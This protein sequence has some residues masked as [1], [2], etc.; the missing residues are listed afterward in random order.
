LIQTKS[1]RSGLR[2]AHER[3]RPKRYDDFVGYTAGVRILDANGRPIHK[4]QVKL[5]SRHREAMRSKYSEYWRMAQDD[6]FNSLLIKGVLQEISDVE[7]PDVAQAIRTMW[8][9]ALKTDHLGFVVRFKARLVAL[10][11]WQRPGIDFVETFAPVARMSSFRM[12]LGLAAELNLQ[13][14]GGDINTAYLNAK[15]TI[16]QYVKGIE[17]FP[18]STRGHIYIVKKAL[19]GLRQAGREW[20]DELNGWLLSHGFNRNSTEPC[21]YY[22]IDEDVI[23]IVLVYVDDILCAT[24]NE[25]SKIKLFSMLGEDY[26]I[27]D[28]G[29]LCEYLG[30]EITQSATEIKICQSKY[31]KEIVEKFGYE[32]AHSV[33]NPMETTSRLIPGDATD[34]TD[35]DFDYR[36]AIGMLM[37]LAT[38]T[39]P[40]LAYS[41]SQLSRFVANPTLKHIGTV[42]RVLRYLVGTLDKGI[43]Y[44]RNCVV[45]N[46]KTINLHGYCD[47]DWANDSETRKSTTGFIFTLAGGAISWMSRRQSIVA[48]STAE[49]EYVAV[50]EA[51]MEAMGL[52]NIMKEMFRS[53]SLDVNIGLDS[54]S[55]YVMAT[56]PTYSRRT[57]HIELRWHFVREQVKHGFVK[58]QKIKGED[59]PADVFT[60]P[61]DKLRLNRLMNVT[62]VT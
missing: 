43:M 52:R 33:G 26:G 32:N 62:G 17:G 40:D 25:D 7:M 48:L 2:E 31:A 36:A 46:A 13:V 59:N 54:Q 6:E 53:K 38:S 37:Y 8:I 24:N 10:G 60:K 15:L 41:M 5:P 56:N 27:K 39:R 4:S 14:Y 11:N 30:V 58:L 47:S 28:Q 42:K 1:R 45:D 55:A 12:V 19:Y 57:R 34:K 51:T 44:T 16:P 29:L 18:C 22:R 23:M 9:Y 20:N 3:Q 35:S 50:C 61:L 49:A 21:L